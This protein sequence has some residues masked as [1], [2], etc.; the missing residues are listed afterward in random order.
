MNLVARDGTLVGFRPE[1]LLPVEDVGSSAARAG[2]SGS[3]Q[4]GPGATTGPERV[5]M[6]LKVDRVEYLSGDR[7]VY[8]TVS[9]IGTE[10]RVIARL[11]S[12]VSTPISAGETHEFAVAGSRLRFFDADSGSRT[13]PVRLGAG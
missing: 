11:P 3:R 9:K 7:H 10:T 6:P 4:P 12:T 1:H 8:G 5:T 13:E 2:G